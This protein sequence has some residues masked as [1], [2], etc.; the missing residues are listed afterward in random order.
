MG[1]WPIICVIVIATGAPCFLWGYRKGYA[2]ATA[3]TYGPDV[4]VNSAGV[5]GLIDNSSEG[6][7]PRE[8]AAH[9]VRG[10]LQRS[11]RP[12]GGGNPTIV[13]EGARTS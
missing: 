8:A 10:V 5:L 1:D 4:L 6:S 12:H 2:K 13:R 9:N 7:P 11:G 3:D